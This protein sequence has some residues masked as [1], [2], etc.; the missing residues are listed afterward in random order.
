MQRHDERDRNEFRQ[1]VQIGEHGIF[2]TVHDQQADDGVGQ[3]GTQITD[4]CRWFFTLG[5][6]QKGQKTGCIVPSTTARTVRILC[7]VVIRLPPSAWSWDGS[8]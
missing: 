8:G 7:V 3:Y 4:E 1:A 5:K 6:D 2:Q